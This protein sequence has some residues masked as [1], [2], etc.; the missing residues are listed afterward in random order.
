MG[1]ETRDRIENLAGTWSTNFQVSGFSNK[2]LSKGGNKWTQSNTMEV[3]EAL[4]AENSCERGANSFQL[5]KLQISYQRNKT[6]LG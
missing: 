2:N 4:G 3:G 5:S 6:P 1:P